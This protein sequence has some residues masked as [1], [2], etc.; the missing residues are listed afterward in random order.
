MVSRSH[1]SLRIPIAS[2][3]V[4]L[5]RRRETKSKNL[6]SGVLRPLVVLVRCLIPKTGDLL[7][8]LA[9]ILAPNL[10]VSL[11]ASI[12][13]SIAASLAAN[14]LANLAASFAARIAANLAASIL[15]SSGKR[16]A[17]LFKQCLIVS[18]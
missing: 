3:L 4:V 7:T 1:C 6:C 11:A 2:V 8:N 9:A 15:D 18:A 5:R 13:A 14:L 16:S 17:L 10:A 12:A